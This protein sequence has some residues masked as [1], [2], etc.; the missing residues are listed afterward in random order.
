M[1]ILDKIRQLSVLCVLI[2]TERTGG[3]QEL[4]KKLGMS[5]GSAYNYLQELKVMGAK[6]EYDRQKQTYYFN[7][8][9]DF[10]FTILLK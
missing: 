2:K 5:K 9:F 6:I 1:T 4:A 10:K 3:L 8:N 7:N